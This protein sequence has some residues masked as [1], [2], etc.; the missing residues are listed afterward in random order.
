MIKKEN[1]QIGKVL[2]NYNGFRLRHLIKNGGRIGIFT[3]KK[4]YNDNTFG[5][6]AEGLAFIK[7]NL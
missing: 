7:E 4:R 5:S 2:V 3:G 1:K 6:K